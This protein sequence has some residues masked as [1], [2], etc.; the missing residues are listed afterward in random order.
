MAKRD[1][2]MVRLA[3]S[4]LKKVKV[5]ETKQKYHDKVEITPSASI[6]DRAYNAMRDAELDLEDA[7]HDLASE[8]G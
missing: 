5:L 2:K 1:S 6:Y 4:I 8:L 7:I 3:K